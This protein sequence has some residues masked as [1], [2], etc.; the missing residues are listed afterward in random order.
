MTSIQ[1]IAATQPMEQNK[2]PM[3]SLIRRSSSRMVST[4]AASTTSA[5]M[6]TM[7]SGTASLRTSR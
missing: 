1:A 5:V 7:V 2:A 6:T 4:S 3:T